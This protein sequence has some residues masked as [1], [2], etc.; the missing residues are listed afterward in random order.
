MSRPYTKIEEMSTADLGFSLDDVRARSLDEV[1]RMGAK[2]VL[3][4]AMGEE[5]AEFLGRNRYDRADPTRPGYRNG[6]RVEPRLKC[7]YFYVD[8]TS[9]P[10]EPCQYAISAVDTSGNEGPLCPAVEAPQAR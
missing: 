1:A 5:V 2:L 4:V 9:P 7:A 6:K 8:T 10:G 3:E